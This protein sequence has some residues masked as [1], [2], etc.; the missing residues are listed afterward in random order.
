MGWFNSNWMW[1][2]RGFLDRILMGV[3]SSRGRRSNSSLRPDDVI[4]FWRVENIVNNKML[5]L[6]AEMKLPGKAWLEFHTDTYEGLNKFTVNAYFQSSGFWG[7]IY[8]YS[9]LPFHMFIFKDL[10]KQIEKRS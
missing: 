9:F 7:R 8:W 4:D 5:L 6:R 2:L 3:G 1:R 10:L